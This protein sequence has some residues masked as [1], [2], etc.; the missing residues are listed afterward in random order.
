MGKPDNKLIMVLTIINK[1]TIM[2][3][4]YQQAQRLAFP[5][6]IHIYKIYAINIQHSMEYSENKTS[7]MSLCGNVNKPPIGSNAHLV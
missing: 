6:V 4:I 3:T 2:K 7:D 5:H 1:Q